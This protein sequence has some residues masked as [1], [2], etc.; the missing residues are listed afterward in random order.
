MGARALGKVALVA[1]VA[2][3][4]AGP[5]TAEPPS[6]GLFIPGKSLGA[7]ELGMTR[8]DVQE[9]WGARHGVCRDCPQPAWYFNE[10]PFRPQGTGVV[11]ENGRVAVAFTVWKPG[12]WTTPEGLELGEPGGEIGATYGELT[13][14]EC[15][16]YSA[17]IREDTHASSVFY[18]YED[19][20]WGFGLIRPGRSPC[21]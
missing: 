2:A 19:E 14:R 9:T 18:V 1:A 3:L 15:T 7:V 8:A 17:L 13:R 11:F 6:G 5:A 16:G 20:V 10:Q 12:G 21:L 4:V